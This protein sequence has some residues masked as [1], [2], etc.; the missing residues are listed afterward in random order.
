MPI[1]E[2]TEPSRATWLPHNVI[3]HKATKNL[4][5]VAMTGS[6]KRKLPIEDDELLTSSANVSNEISP[7]FK[8]VIKRV[9]KG[10]N[11]TLTNLR[12]KKLLMEFTR[13]T[14]IEKPI[15]QPT[16]SV[17]A[18]CALNSSI[19]N[20]GRSPDG[21][22]GKK[23]V[24]FCER[25]KTVH[26]EKRPYSKIFSNSPSAYRYEKVGEHH[27]ALESINSSTLFTNIQR[28]N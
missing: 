3:P 2:K 20:L 11:L 8:P 5:S 10:K 26:I 13:F 21:S 17:K 9:G 27:F 15:R 4:N 18:N 14:A 19:L 1:K 12:F 6:S 25:V 7:S 22:Y 24:R 23:K 16:A 28:D